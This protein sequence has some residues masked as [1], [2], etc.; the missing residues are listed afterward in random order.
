M[1]SHPTGTARSIQAR[2]V[3]TS[4]RLTLGATRLWQWGACAA[5]NIIGTVEG[6]IS[7]VATARCMA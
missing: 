4:A 2:P 1:T 5:R 6:N 3:P 7:S